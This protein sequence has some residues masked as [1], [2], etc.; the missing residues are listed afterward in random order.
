MIYFS[1]I[2]C[3]NGFHGTGKECKSIC[4]LSQPCHVDAECRNKSEA[5]SISKPVA[6]SYSDQVKSLA[7]NMINNLTSLVVSAKMDLTEPVIFV[8][9]LTSVLSL[10]LPARKIRFA[11]TLS[12]VSNATAKLVLN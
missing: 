3:K 4:D 12:V 5:N 11:S 2:K 9:I 7:L 10:S 1:R 6:N 8:T